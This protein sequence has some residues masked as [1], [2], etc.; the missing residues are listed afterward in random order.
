MSGRRVFLQISTPGRCR[1]GEENK[2]NP[3]PER[4]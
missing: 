3:Q 2:T 1:N 4:R